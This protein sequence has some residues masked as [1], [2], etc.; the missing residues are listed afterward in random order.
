MS[1]LPTLSR[2]KRMK[3]LMLARSMRSVPGSQIGLFMALGGPFVVAASV[4]CVRAM[5]SDY[6]VSVC[7]VEERR[8]R[9]KTPARGRRRS[10][11]GRSRSADD[12]EILLL[13]A[14]RE[15]GAVPARPL[16]AAGPGLAGIGRV[17]VFR[18]HL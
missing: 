4:Q 7:T 3:R 13:L 2:T 16:A 10:L 14:R 6:R 12:Q 17:A 1:S 8:A 11:R 9:K 18:L 15:R 5:P